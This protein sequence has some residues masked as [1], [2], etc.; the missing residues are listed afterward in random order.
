MRTF[1][2]VT[3]TECECIALIAAPLS[4][5]YNIKANVELKPAIGRRLIISINPPLNSICNDELLYDGS[6][7]PEDMVADWLVDRLEPYQQLKKYDV[8]SSNKEERKI[9]IKN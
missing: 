9:N 7:L 8:I 5:F 1:I 3:Q 2:E 6:K 4:H